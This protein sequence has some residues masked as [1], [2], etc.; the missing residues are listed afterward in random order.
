MT[1][2]RPGSVGAAPRAV[3]RALAFFAATRAQTLA[4]LAP[5]SQAQFD[6]SPAPGRW[7]V[8]EVADHLV[9]AER[10]Y[11]EE[12]AQLIGLA[13]A[14]ER[15]YLRRTFAE[16]NVS[17]LH[18]PTAVLS[19]IETPLG[20]VTPFI[21]G[22]VRAMVTEFPLLRTRNPDRTTPH[23]RRSGADLRADLS[24][25]LAAV[26]ALIDENDDLDF[27]AMVSE[28]PL[29]GPTTVPQIFHF[30][31]LH[32]RRHQGQMERVRRSGQFPPG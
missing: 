14:G 24:R 2:G 20:M 8:G 17:P 3:D 21:P 23:P 27:S 11:R 15:P 16:V 29:T 1:P 31:A 28:H 10:L 19:M 6:F 18:L 30:L 5:L 13:R 12:V 9:L 7:S 32:E 26:R 22:P 25:G 4:A